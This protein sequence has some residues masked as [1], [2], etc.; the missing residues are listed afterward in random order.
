[1]RPKL[2]KVLA[3]ALCRQMRHYIFIN[4]ANCSRLSRVVYWE[5]SRK[6]W[7][8]MRQS[9]G[10]GGRGNFTFAFAGGGKARRKLRRLLLLWGCSYWPV[11]KSRYGC[12]DLLLVWVTSIFQT[13]TYV[14]CLSIHYSSLVC[15]ANCHYKRVINN[16][17]CSSEKCDKLQI[18]QL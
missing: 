9:T 10:G 18:H 14:Q 15:Y 3:G 13:I 5:E 7:G 16:W 1:M 2:T 4:S 6:S 8:R 17:N 12:E 11:T